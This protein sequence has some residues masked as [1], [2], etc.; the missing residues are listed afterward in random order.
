MNTYATTA[1]PSWFRKN[2]LLDMSP[3]EYLRSLVTPGNA[4]MALFV[5]VGLPLFLY[6]FYAGLGAVTNLSQSQPWGLWIGFDMMCGIALAAGGFTIGASVE[7]FNLKQY[8]A[9]ERPAI[10]TGF[11]GYLL[12]VIGL[13]ADLGKPWNMIQIFQQNGT[14]SVLFEVAWCVCC[15]TTVLS[16]EFA[17]PLFEW[18][19]WKRFYQPLRKCLLALTVL[20]VIFS[21]MHQ[22]ALGSLFIIAPGKQHPLWWSQWVYAFFF[23]TAIIAGISMVVVESTLSHK[24]FASQFKGHHVDADALTIGLGKAGAVILFAYFFLKLQGVIDAH[25]WGYIGQGFLGVWWLVEMLG[26]VLLPALLYAYGARNRSA[27][28]VRVAAVIAVVGIVVNRLNLS[29]VAWDYGNPKHYWPSWIEIMVSVFL[30]T[31]GV[32]AFRWI[33]NRMPVLH[34]PADLA[35]EH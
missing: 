18:L 29:I 1:N 28:V 9:I 2:I 3:G 25:A 27:T 14:R 35:A 33:V 10:L 30:V 21:T 12:A 15:Y 31:L 22:S 20:S 6:R 4:L 5:V 16:L 13:I 19:G 11:L 24:V 32:I 26:F 34:E 7:I 8:H 17:V 23:I